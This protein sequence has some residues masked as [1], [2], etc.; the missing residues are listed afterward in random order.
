MTEEIELTRAM[1]LILIVM[2]KE[3]RHGYG[4]LTDI[5]QITNGD[6]DVSFGTLYRSLHKLVKQGL[7]KDVPGLL[8]PISPDYDDERRK[9]YQITEAGKQALKLEVDR[10]ET[11][12][13]IARETT[14]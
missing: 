9:Y 2:T 6:Y 11:L 4:I 12:L 3:P 7:L 14:K 8:L 10:L 13:Q 5:R 1:T